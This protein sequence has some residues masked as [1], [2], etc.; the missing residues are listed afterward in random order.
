MPAALDG[1]SSLLLHLRDFRS[2]TF[3]FKKEREASDVFESI[4]GLTVVCK[5]RSLFDGD[6]QFTNDAASVSQLYA[7]YYSPNPPLPTSNG[8]LLYSPREEFSRM[9][10]GSRTKAWRFTEINKDYSVRFVPTRV[11][12]IY[13]NHAIVLPYLSGHPSS[14]KPDKR[15]YTPIR[16]KVQE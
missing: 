11:V 15:Y 10:I 8:W 1:S 12:L 9:G 5:C 4:K 13:S 14:P 6:K 7:F 2:L 16:I 3:N